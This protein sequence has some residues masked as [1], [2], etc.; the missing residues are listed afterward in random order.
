MNA[1]NF[2]FRDFL[3]NNLPYALWKGNEIEIALQNVI[4]LMVIDVCIEHK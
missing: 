4:T 1:H 3:F 2:I